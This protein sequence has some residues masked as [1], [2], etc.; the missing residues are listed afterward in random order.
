MLFFEKKDKFIYDDEIPNVETP[1]NV[2]K[3]N[4]NELAPIKSQ[5]DNPN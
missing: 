5:Q 1:I 3:D 4:P 2:E